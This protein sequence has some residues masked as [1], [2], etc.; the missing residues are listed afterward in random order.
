MRHV[1]CFR[2][3]LTLGVVLF[4]CS[5]GLYAAGSDP[6]EARQID[7]T[8]LDEKPDGSCRVRW[9]DP[10]QKRA[11]EASYRCDP[12]RSDLLKAPE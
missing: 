2:W 6:P 9:I 10:Y 1:P 7:L 4:A 8:V 12:G 5:V 11:R 3:V